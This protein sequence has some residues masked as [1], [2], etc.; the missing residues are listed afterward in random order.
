MAGTDA[1]LGHAGAARKTEDLASPGGS[2]P[3]RET[4]HRR[5]AGRGVRADQEAGPGGPRPAR[6]P[7]A[8]DGGGRGARSDVGGHRRPSARPHA[9]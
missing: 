3:T 7:G 2:Q 8:V 9:R 5:A 6:V 1:A 4:P